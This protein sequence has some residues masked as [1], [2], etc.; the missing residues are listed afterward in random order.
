M[1]NG[2]GLE[3]QY[4]RKTIGGSNPSLS[5]LLRSLRVLTIE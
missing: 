4:R 1:V 2:A 3:N 5:V